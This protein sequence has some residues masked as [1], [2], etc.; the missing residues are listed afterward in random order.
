MKVDGEKPKASPEQNIGEGKTGDG[1]FDDGQTFIV[2]KAE[3]VRF[4]S[5]EG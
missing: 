3:Y 5:P 1:T 4:D 2:W